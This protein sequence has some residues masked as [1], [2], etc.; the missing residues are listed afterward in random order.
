[1]YKT[2]PATLLDYEKQVAA[3]TLD[4]IKATAQRYLKSDNYVQVVLYP[5]KQ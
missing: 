5:E 4:D 2:D 1:L 3:M